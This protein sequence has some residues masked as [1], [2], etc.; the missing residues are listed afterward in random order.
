MV[1]HMKWGG[2]GAESYLEVDVKLNLTLEIYTQPFTMMP[3]SAI[4]GPGNMGWKVYE[5]KRF[6]REGEDR[7]MEEGRPNRTVEGGERSGRT[8]EDG[9]ESSR[10]AEGGESSSGVMGSSRSVEER[11]S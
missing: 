9:E 3:T 6:R 10:T 11:L 8:M 4:E 7:T 1:N 2:A 5:R